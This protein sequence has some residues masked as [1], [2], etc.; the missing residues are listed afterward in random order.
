MKPKRK[1]KPRP[2]AREWV[3]WVIFTNDIPGGWFYRSPT[4]IDPYSDVRRCLLTE[5][6]LPKEK[7]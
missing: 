3:V 5:A 7:L 6:P 4:G 2:K 1:P